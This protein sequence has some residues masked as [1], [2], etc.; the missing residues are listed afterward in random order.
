MDARTEP[1]GRNGTIGS[2]IAERGG[3]TR[4]FDVMRIGLAIAVLC[5]HSIY[6]TRGYDYNIW[7]GPFRALPSL[8]LPMF[9]ALSG[10]LV[11]GSLLRS[12]TLIEF[13]TLRVLRLVPALF[14]EVCLSAL[15]L[16]PLVTDLP[17][18]S[19]LSDNLF[20]EY[21][22]NVIGHIHYR[23][24][25]VFMHNPVSGTVNLS[26][27]T[28]PY[29]LACYIFL[30]CLAVTTIVRR[31][32]F[33]L[34][35]FAVASIAFPIIGY[36]DGNG[37]SWARPDGKLLVLSFLA[38]LIIFQLRDR[39]PLSVYLAVACGVLSL[40]LLTRP[41]TAYLAPLPVAYVTVFLGLTNPPRI[42][43]LMSGDYSYGVY[44]YAFPMQQTYAF[45]FP[46][47]L[48]WSL[49]ILFAL[50][51]SFALAMIS[52]RF[53]EKPVLSHKRM[54]VALIGNVAG[55]VT[56]RIAAVARINNL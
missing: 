14:F 4:G 41:D 8:I 37:W 36:V 3:Y 10:Y 55:A 9:F 7:S 49:N 12:K 29:E 18:S 21:W 50:P 32:A 6:S 51:T 27:W 23:L 40:L 22:W 30:G 44:L 20:Y 38:G 54:I 15:I 16:G 45:L 34:A 2:R 52:W 47:H 11:A 1:S 26:L 53:I 13:F 33:L 43:V 56:G 5:W 19:Y 42:P 48:H 35:A 39:I 24:P 46:S 28:V 25:G 31:P 17:L